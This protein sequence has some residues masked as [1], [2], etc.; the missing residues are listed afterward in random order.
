MKC[1]FGSRSLIVSFPAE[2]LLQSSLTLLQ[3]SSFD[4]ANEHAAFFTVDRNEDNRG[5]RFGVDNDGIRAVTIKFADQY[6][7]IAI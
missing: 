7:S 3:S 1:T 4:G 2:M 6:L 5:E